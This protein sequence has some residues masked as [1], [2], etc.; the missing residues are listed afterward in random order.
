[1]TILFDGATSNLLKDI[2]AI[3]YE[4][5]ARVYKAASIH[6][7]VMDFSRFAEDCIQTVNKAEEQDLSTNPNALVQTFIDLTARHQ[8]SFF[9]FVHEAHC[10]DNGLFN[11]LMSWV[12][13]ILTF[14]RDGASQ[15]L[16]LEM[17]FDKTSGLNK[18]QVLNEVD[19]CIKWNGKM[20]VWRQERLQKKMAADQSS[21]AASGGGGSESAQIPMGT[22]S[23]ADF[24]LD[25]NDLDEFLYEDSDGDEEL[26]EA[27]DDLDPLEAE[28]KR[29][30]RSLAK[31]QRRYG[32][33]SMPEVSEVYKMIPLFK[34]SLRTVLAN[35]VTKT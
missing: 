28:I 33:P 29:K 12:E 21:A 22:I 14:L 27:I 31:L 18:E 15:Q 19:A 16:D 32:E 8:N 2:V 30:K 34:Q 10:H 6:N 23:G 11:G 13:L 25:Q 35:T 4:P 20:K 5:L 24:G 7:S 1:M 3:F 9:H 17:I 26:E